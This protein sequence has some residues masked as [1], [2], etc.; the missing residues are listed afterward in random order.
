MQPLDAHRPLPKLEAL[1]L[2]EVRVVVDLFGLEPGVHKVV[3]QAFAPEGLTVESVLPDTIEVEIRSP[4]GLVT[5]T[6]TRRTPT[7]TPTPT[8]RP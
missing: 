1:S 3:A 6:P 2:E 5:P 7:P 8:R 4:V